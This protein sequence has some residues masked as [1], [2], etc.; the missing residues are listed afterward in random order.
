MSLSPPDI[1]SL[2]LGWAVLREC[3]MSCWVANRWTLQRASSNNEANIE[4]PSSESPRGLY[5][6]HNINLNITPEKQQIN[7]HFRNGTPEKKACPRPQ[8]N[9]LFSILQASSYQPSVLRADLG[10]WSK[11]LRVSKW[12]TNHIHSTFWDRLDTKPNSTGLQ[13][14]RCSPSIWSRV[15]FRE[16]CDKGYDE[17][18]TEPWWKC[19]RRKGSNQGI[20]GKPTREATRKPSFEGLKALSWR[21]N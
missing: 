21:R 13:F 7:F 2:I 15:A 8:L 19:A 1:S 12:K 9:L 3:Q 11:S 6:W 20:R 18:M 16:Q 4:C 5:K 14:S 10:P 17:C